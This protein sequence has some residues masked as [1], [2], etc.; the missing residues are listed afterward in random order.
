MCSCQCIGLRSL[1]RFVEVKVSELVTLRVLEP[2]TALWICGALL[3]ILGTLQLS[4]G[5]VPQTLCKGLVS[6]LKEIP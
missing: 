3:D 2:Y 6:I 1:R 4:C 5:C